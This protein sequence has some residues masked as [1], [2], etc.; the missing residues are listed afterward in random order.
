MVGGAMVESDLFTV[1]PGA[2]E[3]S[4]ERT[5]E[6]EVMAL[7]MGAAAAE[8]LETPKVAMARQA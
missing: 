5:A 8:G 7:V 2:M 3:D 6:L 1:F 4:E